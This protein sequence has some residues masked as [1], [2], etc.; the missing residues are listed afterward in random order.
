MAKRVANIDDACRKLIGKN[1]NL[2]VPW[3][4][5]TSYLYY[6]KDASVIE[7]AT[8]DLICKRLKDEWKWIE[9]PHKHL[10]DLQALSAGTG[11]QMREQDYPALVKDAAELA[12]AGRVGR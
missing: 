8:Y 4:L 6:I 5:M 2:L 9:H 11:Y 10:I 3:Y 1:R 12:A 7:D